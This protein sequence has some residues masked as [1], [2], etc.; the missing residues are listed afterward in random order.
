MQSHRQRKWHHTLKDLTITLILWGY[1]TIGFVVLFAPLYACARLFSRDAA[2]AFQRLNA[3]FYR[4]FFVLLRFLVPACQWRVDPAVKTIRGS[5][6]V[7]NHVSYLDPIL[8]I[9]F[10][11]RHTTIAKQRLFHIP[12]YGR[13]LRI[14]G[15][16][17]SSA[18]GPLADLILASME[19][20]PDFLSSGGNLII[21]PEGTRSRDGQIGVLNTGAFKIAR[22]C[23]APIHV[24][25]MEKTDRLFRP[26]RFLFDTR[27]A[28]TVRVEH[29]ACIEPRYDDP[30]FSLK[31]L[32][33]QVRGVLEDRRL[34]VR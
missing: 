23:N 10:F 29:L 31:G 6:I 14:S 5:V 12:L 32:M 30:G 20:M 28:N 11:P 7:A 13:M 27:S 25:Y 17:P 16:I 34:P 24:L 26:G 2:T 21:F 22:L 18:D 1:Y 9:S 3:R 19:K 8:L 4:L 15:Y 33:G